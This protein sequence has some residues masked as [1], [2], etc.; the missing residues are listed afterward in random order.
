MQFPPAPPPRNGF[1]CFL[2]EKITVVFEPGFSPEGFATS[3]FA[4]LCK[5]RCRA[6]FRRK[7][8]SERTPCVPADIMSTK[9]NP[10]SP[11]QGG[12]TKLMIGILIY[13]HAKK[14]GLK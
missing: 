4:F 10:P 5:D 14:I 12:R 9:K 8:F 13:G 11:G 1:Y 3:W 6:E 7:A 2:G